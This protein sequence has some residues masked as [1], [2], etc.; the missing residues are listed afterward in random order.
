MNHSASLAV[1]RT[2]GAFLPP[3]LQTLPDAVAANVAGIRARTPSTIMAVVKAD[4]YG[5]GAVTVAEAAVAA[6]AGWLGTTSVAEASV[7]RAAGLAVPILTWLHPSGIDAD[8]AA[9]AGV[10]VAV[11]SVDELGAL[12]ARTGP[13]VRVHLHVDTG[14]AR[15]GCPRGRWDELI[16]LARRGR[17]DRKVRVTGVMGHLPLADAADPAANAPAVA[18]MREA[19]RA[20][21]AA[22][23]GAPLAHLATT[24]GALTDPATHF[25]MVRVGAGLVGID[26]SGTTRLHGASRLTAPVVH[27]AAVR[28]GTPVGYDGAYVTDRA[29]NLSVLPVGYADGIPRERSPQA[30]VEIRGRRFPIVGRVSMD[31]IVI[32][33]GAESF[34]V[35]TSATVFGPDGGAVPS[36]GDWARWAGTIPHTIVTGIGPR[37]KRSIG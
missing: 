5:H 9:A 32:D 28:A 26:P 10:D 1:R 20:V 16:G 21:R 6:G 4:G 2:R 30:G 19:R 3:T 27:T 15:G 7:L 37:V 31:Q 22:G 13:A 33:T 34:P 29:T 35:G 25:D 18:A 23:L 36:V 17:Q 12:V 8:A 24:S 14:M 11:G